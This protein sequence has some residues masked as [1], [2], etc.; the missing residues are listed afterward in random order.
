MD[1]RRIQHFVHVAELGSL[2]KAAHRLN[3]VQPALSQSIKRLEEDIGAIMFVRSRKGMEL[4]EHGRVF[5]KYAYGILNQFNRAKE[6]ISTIGENPK[7]LVSIAMT[8]SALHA[9]TVPVYTKLKAGFPGITLNIEE[10]LAANIKQG[11]EAGWYDLVVSHLAKPDDSIHIEN[12]IQEDLFLVTPYG[13]KIDSK[14]VEFSELANTLLIMPQD[15]HGVGGEFSK[16]ANEHGFAIKSAQV[17][18]ALH[19]T[20]QLIEAG[21]GCSILPWSAINDRIKQK[22]LNAQKIVNPKIYHTISMVYPAHKPLTQASLVVMEIIRE[23]IAEIHHD[24]MWSGKLMT[25]EPG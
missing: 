19:P 8:A 3:I 24:G 12:L 23:S 20:L 22:K 21:F 9:L 15:H 2:S 18:G 11:F 5:L 1:F 17:S 7:G 13:K 16:Q 14:L 25:T 4:T 10:G 6:S